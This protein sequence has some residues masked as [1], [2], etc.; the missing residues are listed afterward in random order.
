MSKSKSLLVKQMNQ[1]FLWVYVMAGIEISGDNWGPLPD[2]HFWTSH[3]ERGLE[4]CFMPRD[5][6]SLYLLIELS[7]FLSVSFCLSGFVFL[8]VP[9]VT[10]GEWIIEIRSLVFDLDH[11]FPC[12]MS[13][14]EMGQIEFMQARGAILTAYLGTYI[15][16]LLY[17]LEPK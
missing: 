6:K 17:M 10:S 8:Q 4:D 16:V 1:A 2:T 15:F 7:I 9:A 13:I 11:S 5:Q 12:G 3:T 14:E